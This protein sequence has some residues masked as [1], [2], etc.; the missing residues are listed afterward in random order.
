M[1]ETEEMENEELEETEEETEEEKS[2]QKKEN[3]IEL[4]FSMDAIERIKTEAESAK[5]G[6][7]KAIGAYLVEKMANDEPLKQAY[8][9]R[10]ITLKAVCGFITECAKKKLGGVNG[11][12]D[13][14]EV[15]GWAI[16]Y[17]QDEPVKVSESNSYTLTKEEKESARAKAI[18]E[19][20]AAER[21]KLE[22]K[23]KREAE[24]QQAKIRKA[25]EE[26]EKSGQM[27]LFDD[28]SLFGL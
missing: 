6:L 4:D 12:V 5:D 24:R 23:A 18:R 15:Y 2:S 26:R 9:D 28:M 21:K 17:V 27:S 25:E 1:T 7:S 16:H 11:A 10:K 20:E 19:Y 8:K 14:E 22:D 13:D 3:K